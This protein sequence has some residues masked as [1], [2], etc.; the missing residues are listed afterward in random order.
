LPRDA[1]GVAQ[2]PDD[3]SLPPA[4]TLIE[5]QRLLDEGRPFSA[6]EVLEAAWKAAPAGEHELWRG[7]AQLAVGLTHLQRGRPRGAIALLRR[8]AARVRPYTGRAPYDIDATGL[9]AYADALADRVAA[10]GLPDAPPAPPRLTGSAH[11]EP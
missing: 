11:T 9:A 3:F 10:G 8:A 7:L 1:V 4:D 5:A 2:L 6:H